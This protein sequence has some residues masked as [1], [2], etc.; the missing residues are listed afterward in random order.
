MTHATSPMVDST[1]TGLMMLMC[2]T[3]SGL[4]GDE[5][6]V[7]STTTMAPMAMT[8]RAA[9]MVVMLLDG[10]CRSGSALA[11]VVVV[12][13]FSAKPSGIE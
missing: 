10:G 2:C 5:L 1:A 9:Q 6:E 11:F 13:G 8:L 3:A 7:D 12:E 4:D